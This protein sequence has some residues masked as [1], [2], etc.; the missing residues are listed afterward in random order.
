MSGLKNAFYHR[1]NS[2]QRTE[3]PIVTKKDAI[4]TILLNERGE[5]KALKKGVVRAG[6]TKLLVWNQF[7]QSVR[8]LASDSEKVRFRNMALFLY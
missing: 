1:I 2:L 8:F 6:P 4:G 3:E 7:D 5:L